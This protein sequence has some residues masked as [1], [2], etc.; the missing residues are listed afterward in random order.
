[1]DDECLPGRTAPERHS[2]SPIEVGFRRGSPGTRSFDR[3]RCETNSGATIGTSVLCLPW[4]LCGSPGR[5]NAHLNLVVQVSVVS[6]SCPGQG[7]D[8][9]STVPCAHSGAAL[10][11]PSRDHPCWFMEPAAGFPVSPSLGGE[12]SFWWVDSP[13]SSRST[14][15]VRCCIPQRSKPP[16]GAAGTG[17]KVPDY[18]RGRASW[19]GDLRVHRARN[20]HRCRRCPAM[21]AGARWMTWRPAPSRVLDFVESIRYLRIRSSLCGRR[22]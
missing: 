2:V 7:L 1:M 17:T 16:A 21:L 13:P 8:V 5:D 20:G 11:D 22:R 6:F 19:I 4:L 18:S 3:A 9:R 10:N 15:I 14:P 12:A